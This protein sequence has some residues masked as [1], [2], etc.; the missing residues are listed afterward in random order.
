[1]Q[2][3]F[4]KNSSGWAGGVETAILGPATQECKNAQILFVLQYNIWVLVHSSLSKQVTMRK[5]VALNWSQV[6]C[7][8]QPHWKMHKNKK[9]IFEA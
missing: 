7:N 9:M 3:N 2:N 4:N 1:M 8:W 6:Y 5:N